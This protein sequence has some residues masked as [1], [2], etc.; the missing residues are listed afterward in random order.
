MQFPK[1]ER[2]YYISGFGLFLL[3][4]ELFLLPKKMRATEQNP[5]VVDLAN[6]MQTRCSVKGEAHNNAFLH[7]FHYGTLSI[8]SNHRFLQIPLVNPRVSIMPPICR[9]LI[10]FPWFFIELLYLQEASVGFQKISVAPV[11]LVGLRTQTQNAASFER[12]GPKRKPWP[13]GKSLNRKKW[14]RCV[15]WTLAF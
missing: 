1:D 7:E 10:W 12:K 14:S 5:S 11:Y 2:I 9:L 6:N 3:G 13:R 4:E 15:F 8:W